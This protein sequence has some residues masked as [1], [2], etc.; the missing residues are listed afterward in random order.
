M[1]MKRQ[2]HR[3]D[4]NNG[5]DGWVSGNPRY[6]RKKAERGKNRKMGRNR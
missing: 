6:D 1:T 2:K 5:K 3:R 4:K